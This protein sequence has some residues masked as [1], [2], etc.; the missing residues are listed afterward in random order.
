MKTIYTLFI[1]S[2]LLIMALLVASF[3]YLEKTSHWDFYYTI[4]DGGQIRGDIEMDVY[5]TEQSTLYKSRIRNPYQIDT[6]R[7]LVRMNVDK[8]TSFLKDYE[9]ISLTGGIKKAFYLKRRGNAIDFLALAESEFAYLD[10]VEVKRDALFFD[11]I[12]PVTYIPFIKLYNFRRGGSQSFNAIRRE[13]GLLPPSIFIITFTS[14]RDEY[15][16]VNGRKIKTE[17]IIIKS[18]VTDQI[19][20]WVDKKRHD[21]VKIH[22]P[23]RNIYIKPSAGQEKFDVLEYSPKDEYG[24]SQKITFVSGN[25]EFNGILS[26]PKKEGVYPAIIMIQNENAKDEN[27]AGVFADLSADLSKNG[28]VSFRFVPSS[29]EMKPK[30]LS[31]S[32]EDELASIKSGIDILES[33]RFVDPERIGIIAQS[34]VNYVIPTFIKNEPRI[35]AWIMLSPLRLVPVVDT[36]LEIVKKLI[37]IIQK[38]DNG[39]EERLSRCKHVT[40]QKAEE[41]QS[42]WKNIMGKKVFLKR[43]R[44]ILHLN[45]TDEAPDISIPILLLEGKKDGYYST[46]YLKSLEDNIKIRKN[47]NSLFVAFKQLNHYLAESVKSKTLRTHYVMDKVVL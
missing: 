16:K 46:T 5:L 22:I 23:K 35:K 27:I 43:V 19:Y 38:H 36:E 13:G 28:Y 42:N 20:I 7:K 11:S 32:I 18:I 6:G 2:I 25:T 34:D 10:N 33:F 26:R 4:E 40:V 8:K 39:F 14:I 45:A 24:F 37:K 41:T 47:N 12:S 17:C 21:I 9:E 3:V 15:L 1:L 31:I 44:E 30:F 29:S